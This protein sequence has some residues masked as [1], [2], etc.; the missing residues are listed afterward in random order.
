VATTGATAQTAC[1]S[2]YTSTGGPGSGGVSCF[3]TGP[4]NAANNGTCSAG[5]SLYKNS[6]STYTCALCNAG[7]F[8]SSVTVSAN[9]LAVG[10]VAG[11]TACAAPKRT[12][13]VIGSTSCQ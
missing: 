5:N 10:A 3:A 6:N 9:T 7:Y 1:P 12:N 13:G 2:G 11:C 8:N 4:I